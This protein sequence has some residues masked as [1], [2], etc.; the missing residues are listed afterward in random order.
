[1]HGSVYMRWRVYKIQQNENRIVGKF[2]I[3]IEFNYV[4]STIQFSLL[5]FYCAQTHIQ[6]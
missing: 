6:T 1:M 5:P 3:K 4:D 2:A